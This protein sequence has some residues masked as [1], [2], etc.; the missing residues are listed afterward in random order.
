M[1]STKLLSTNSLSRW[2]RRLIGGC[3]VKHSGEDFRWC[4]K[5]YW[6]KDTEWNGGLTHWDGKAY[7]G[8]HRV[9][10]GIED[11]EDYGDVTRLGKLLGYYSHSAKVIPFSY[12]G[13]SIVDFVLW[14]AL[15]V[16]LFIILEG[17]STL[18][19]C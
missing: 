2:K 5:S 6:G 3:W 8:Y 17:T 1:P 7:H 13:L 18:S 15:F 4:I 19:S 14:T 16:I 12:P 9:F 10:N 11:F